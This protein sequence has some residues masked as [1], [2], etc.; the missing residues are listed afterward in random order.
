M[1]ANISVYLYKN[2]PKKSWHAE[3]GNCG[4]LEY[5]NIIQGEA[6]SEI[7][8][9]HLFLDDSTP[10]DLTEKTIT[11]YFTKPDGENMFLQAD[12]PRSPQQTA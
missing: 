10:L 8:N 6:D 9:F 7:L 5:I 11:F 4:E 1:V 3:G 2:N 12:I